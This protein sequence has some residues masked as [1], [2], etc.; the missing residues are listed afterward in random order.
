M[1][2]SEAEKV[3]FANDAF[4]S[5]SRKDIEF[6]K[7]LEKAL[8]DYKPPKDLNVPQR[9]LVIFRDESDFTGVEY[10]E[11]VEKHLKSSKKMI[12]ICSP[13]ACKSKYV[14]DEIRR[15]AEARG[16]EDII[17]VL[18]SGIP[19]NEATPGY[20]DEMAFPEAL[21]EVQKM[22][23]AADYRGFVIKKDKPHKG[24]FEGPWYTILANLYDLSRAEVEQ[25]EKKRQARARRITYSMV[26]GIITG[27]IIA[28]ILIGISRQEAIEQRDIAEKRLRISQAW[29]LAGWSK[30]SFEIDRSRSL[31]LATAS[32]LRT[33]KV[34]G[35]RVFFA[36]QTLRELLAAT[37]KGTS[38]HKSIRESGITFRP[39]MEWAF[40][41]GSY[42][43]S[44][45][46][47]SALKA[48]S[49]T[50]RCSKGRVAAVGFS[51]DG[52]LM[53]TGNSEGTTL[54]WN[55]RDLNARPTILRGG[56][57]GEV[58]ALTFSPDGRKLATGSLDRTI[59]LWDMIGLK[60][61]SIEIEATLQLRIEGQVACLAFSPDSQRLAAG[62]S[63]GVAY[64]WTLD[65]YPLR[66]VELK[67]HKDAVFSISFSPDG[68]HL[69]SGSHDKTLRLWWAL[70]DTSPNSLVLQ[71]F[72][73]T[74][75]SVAFSKD[76]RWLATG[77]SDKT[78][79][80][81]NATNFKEEPRV[82]PD[83]KGTVDSVAFTSDGSVLATAGADEKI[84][85]WNIADK[86]AGPVFLLGH[87]KS[88]L[89]LAFS[90]DSSWLASGSNDGTT[91]LWNMNIDVLMQITC[92]AA[93][94]N[95]SC[96]EW[97]RFIG[98]EPYSSICPNFPHPNCR[99]GRQNDPL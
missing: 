6:A 55:L 37:D 60:T 4:I 76:G 15:F 44:S 19:N 50:L 71:D 61:P 3:E 41:G 96:K 9:N 54:L 80:I 1:I 33:Y 94:R 39:E 21:C 28:V 58:F 46:N 35:T 79:K 65:K 52:S 89:C 12:V 27:L 87:E 86:Q 66:L 23:L 77:S 69:A 5:Y 84:R 98:G 10:E 88:V 68:K 11:S 26:G 2:A 90:P 25:R 31:L 91:R 24:R 13:D 59:C 73:G 78:V 7:K 67:G 22:P 92:E 47:L 43:L 40:V 93:G 63:N 18:L 38:S 49:V 29:Q 53:A 70:E 97:E 57:K 51:P 32:V 62:G 95:L 30:I 36:E 74:V 99:E 45:L 8:E 64:L 72:G 83:F 17:P 81:W 48:E 75:D 85:L 14:N 34:D 42:G 20:E 82:L 16:A 56:H